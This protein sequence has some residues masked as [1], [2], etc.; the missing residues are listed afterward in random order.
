[1]A[2]EACDLLKK[3]F[4]PYHIVPPHTHFRDAAERDIQTFIYYFIADLRSTDA[5]YPTQ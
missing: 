3:T 5:K 1:M 2:N 4:I